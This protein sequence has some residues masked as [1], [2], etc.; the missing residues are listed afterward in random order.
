MAEEFDLAIVGAGAAGLRA[1]ELAARLGAR[2]ALVEKSRPGGD[3]LWTGDIPSKALARAASGA[4]TCRQG[5]DFGMSAAQGAARLSLIKTELD[6]AVAQVHQRASPERLTSLGIRVILAAGRFLD[7]RTLRA[8]EEEVRARH[9]LIATGANPVIPNAPGLRETPYFTHRTIFANMRLPNR[10]AVVGGGPVG[11]ELA[12]AYA[13]LGSEVV[14]IAEEILPCESGAARAA[15]LGAWRREGLR[16]IFGRLDAARRER[17]VIRVESGDEVVVADAL[18]IA[19]GRRPAIADLG[20][21]AAGVRADSEGIIT[22][23]DGRTSTRGIYACGDCARGPRFTH[24]A[25]WQAER[26]VRRVLLP[27]GRR[28]PAPPP[29]RLTFTDPAIAA[30]G[31]NAAEARARWGDSARVLRREVKE[32]DRAACEGERE[33][34]VELIARGRH[35]VGATVV[36]RHAEAL[37]GELA[38]AIEN[39]LELREIA[40]AMRP[41]PSYGAGLRRWVVDMIVEELAAAAAGAGRWRRRRLARRLW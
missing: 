32:F 19:T 12:Q 30:I 10:L 36:A 6:S 38:A 28:T 24:W 13:R 27:G 26:V 3:S 21:E 40:D 5:L 2:V 9:F 34:F 14:V 8:G 41:F 29:P 33:G 7:A 18:L 20:L 39:G 35:L 16:V 22:D 1:A 37:A 11:C 23:A 17:E 15:L 31:P 4:L 25:E